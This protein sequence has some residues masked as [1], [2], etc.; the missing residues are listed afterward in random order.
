MQ[1]IDDDM[2]KLSHYKVM[3]SVSC[4]K[5]LTSSVNEYI[6]ID[7]LGNNRSIMLSLLNIEYLMPGQD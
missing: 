7:R 1:F 4:Y 3:Q 2:I 5:G 6:I